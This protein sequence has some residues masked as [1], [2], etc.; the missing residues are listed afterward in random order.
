MLS[1][2]LKEKI[3]LILSLKLKALPLYCEG[4]FKEINAIPDKKIILASYCELLKVIK[5][6]HKEGQLS[7]ELML[8]ILT[9]I[10]SPPLIEHLAQ[11]LKNNLFED[12]MA[13]GYVPTAPRMHEFLQQFYDYETQLAELSPLTPKLAHRTGHTLS[14]C[15]SQGIR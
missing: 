4:L 8:S 15:S 5:P 1:R 3:Q 7:G 2:E 14:P 11:N 12:L 6:L 13:L 9:T 10:L